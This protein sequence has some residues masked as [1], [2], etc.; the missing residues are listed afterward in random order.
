MPKKKGGLGFLPVLT[1]PT[2]E[3][4]NMLS[5]PGSY[6]SNEPEKD[7]LFQCLI[8]EYHALHTFTDSAGKAARKGQAFELMER[9][10]DGASGQ[11][12]IFFMG[13]PDPFMRYLTAQNDRKEEEKKAEIAEAEGCDSVTAQ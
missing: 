3:V 1:K 8:R 11:R 4:G 5:I 7:V 6:W 9:G 13:Y 2:D 10:V 12:E